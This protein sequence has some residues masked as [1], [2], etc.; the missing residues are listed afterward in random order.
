MVPP[1]QKALKPD[2]AL[3][4]TVDAAG[5]G[6]YAEAYERAKSMGLPVVLGE[7]ADK[8][9]AAYAQATALEALDSRAISGEKLDHAIYHYHPSIEQVRIWF[10]QAGL[11]IEEEGTGDGYAHFLARKHA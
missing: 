8:L 3:Y 11:A 4:V 7:V 9:D 5:P 10:D 2:G 6:E 1:F